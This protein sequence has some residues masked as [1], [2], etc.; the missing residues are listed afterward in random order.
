MGL[1]A[2]C[3][4]ILLRRAS[5]GGDNGR[6]RSALSA[7]LAGTFLTAATLAAPPAQAAGKWALNGTYTATS[8]GEWARTN[9]VF[10]DEVSV[11]AI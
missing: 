6:M 5:A 7:L 11:R 2:A 3:S 4:A 9:D 1:S 8:N 10:H